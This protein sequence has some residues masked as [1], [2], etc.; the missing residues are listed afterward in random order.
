MN[1]ELLTWQRCRGMQ[2]KQMGKDDRNNYL[3]NCLS[4]KEI[5]GVIDILKVAELRWLWV[6]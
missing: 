1:L 6:R 5:N 3:V 2:G 4:I